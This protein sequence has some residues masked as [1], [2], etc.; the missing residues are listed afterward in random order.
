MDHH[1]TQECIE[2]VGVESRIVKEIV[3]M[4]VNYCLLTWALQSFAKQARHSSIPSKAKT[5]IGAFAK[6]NI[7]WLC[8]YGKWVLKSIC[9]DGGGGNES[10]AAVG[11]QSLAIVNGVIK[12]DRMFALGWDS[13]V[14]SPVST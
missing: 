8:N 6:D 5:N 11:C 1:D 4:L 3:I 12:L 14:L 2:T 9:R 7:F 13:G 10:A